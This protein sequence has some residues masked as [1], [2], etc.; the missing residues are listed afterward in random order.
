MDMKKYLLVLLPVEGRRGREV[1]DVKNITCN[2][3]LSRMR[4]ELEMCL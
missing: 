1:G 3:T 4:Y 2:A